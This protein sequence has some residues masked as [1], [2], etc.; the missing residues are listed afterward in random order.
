MMESRHSA[1]G[2][3]IVSNR[4]IP[5]LA[6]A[7]RPATTDAQ[8]HFASPGHPPSPCVRST[9]NPWYRSE[10]LDDKG[11]P[12]LEVWRLEQ[13]EYQFIYGDGTEFRVR[14]NGRRVDAYT[15]SHLSLAD[16]AYYVNGPIL[17]FLLRQRGVVALHASGVEVNGAAVLFIGPCGAGKSTTAAALASRGHAVITEDLAPIEQSGKEFRCRPGYPRINLWPDSV[18]A[19]FG[20]LSALPEVAP[21]WPKRYLEVDQ[22]RFVT[23]NR[24]V[25]AIYAIGPRWGPEPDD[26]ASGVEIKALTPSSALVQL[27]AHTY[28][29]YL[30]STEQR[31]KELRLWGSLAATVP[32]RSLSHLAGAIRE[33]CRA[34]EAD[35]A[36]L[37]PQSR[38]LGMN[39]GGQVDRIGGKMPEEPDARAH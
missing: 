25:A 33:L 36:A 17:A 7:T 24:P 31:S 26:R 9:S 28:M 29:N 30:P 13:S 11:K 5:G 34:I 32:I 37:S 38:A 16:T 14:E 35:V 18:Y 21:P 10:E 23:G 6:A 27:M 2:L 39:N 15:P 3:T 20:S 8:I 19:L 4:L 1:Y 22:A 12:S